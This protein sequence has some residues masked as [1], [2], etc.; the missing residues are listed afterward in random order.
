MRS[1]TRSAAGFTEGEWLD[2]VLPPDAVCSGHPITF[3]CFSETVRGGRSATAAKD[4]PE[5]AD[6]NL[7]R[8]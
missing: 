7:E 5:R 8:S 4:N 1:L 3:T 2:Q 6:A